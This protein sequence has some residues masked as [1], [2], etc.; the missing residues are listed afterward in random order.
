MVTGTVAAPVK[1][2]RNR[3][4]SQFRS[5]VKATVS[6]HKDADIFASPAEV[7]D[8]LATHFGESFAVRVVSRSRTTKSGMPSASPASVMVYIAPLGYEFAATKERGVR[9]D[10]ETAGIL[11]TLAAG[12][13]LD[14]N[15][16][17]SI[18]A[19]AKALAAKAT[20]K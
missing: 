20:A 13:G 19:V 11:R 14:P 2:R 18:L 15:D 5:A 3:K 9:L 1:A 10:A 6:I 7:G 17:A 4:A 12:M 16:S 8:V